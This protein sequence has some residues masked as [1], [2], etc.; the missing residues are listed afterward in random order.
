MLACFFVVWRLQKSFSFLL[1]M[2]KSAG[3][4]L[5]TV[6]LRSGDFRYLGLCWRF[7]CSSSNA[8]VV[9][10]VLM[11]AFISEAQCLCFLLGYS[12]ALAHLF[13]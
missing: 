3:C 11:N 7:L 8:G 2:C 9:D 5:P 6:I 1:S 4:V 13:A 10:A 12:T